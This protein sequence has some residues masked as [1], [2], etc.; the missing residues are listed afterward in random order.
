[1]VNSNE[2]LKQC[3]ELTDLNIMWL[4]NLLTMSA[5]DEGY[6]RKASCTLN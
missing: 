2:L 3:H 6:Y 4:F 5:S 1:M